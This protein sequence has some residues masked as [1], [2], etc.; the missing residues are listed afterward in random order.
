MLDTQSIGIG[1]GIGRSATVFSGDATRDPW[2]IGLEKPSA[3][4]VRGSFCDKAA[5]QPG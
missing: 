1:R 4:C 3:A 5:F 2:H